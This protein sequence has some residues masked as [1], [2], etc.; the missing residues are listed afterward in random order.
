M[1]KNQY[2]ERINIA[3]DFIRKNINEKIS[4]Q[5]IS[6]FA[7]FSQYHFHRIFAA[8]TG[9]T[10][11]NFI[12]KIK[13]ENAAYR[14]KS[15]ETNVIEI[16]YMTGYETP[17]AFTRAFK[18]YYGVTPSEYKQGSNIKQSK[19]KSLEN[20][21]YF[22]DM[23]MKNFIGIKNIEDMNVIYVSKTGKYS[24][25]ANEAWSVLCKFAYSNS[26][27]KENKVITSDSK[28]IGIGYDDPEVTPEEKLRYD[29][30]ITV[31]HDIEISGEIKQKV[32]E[33]GKYAVF[34]HKG[35]YK[36]FQETFNA[37][38]S[39]WLPKSNYK[40]RETP[41]FEMYLN[42]D[43]KRTKPENLRTEIYIPIF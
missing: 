31:N 34:L 18:Q 30:C 41:C 28:F 38:F 19:Q 1:D 21:N 33:G 36:N 20:C 24:E 12:R 32:I 22:K 11:G 35:P 4:L 17:A 15:N 2:K 42:R 40:L 6:S 9:E 29:A 10:I 37:I 39:E 27:G 3:T 13:L 5:E 25:S 7:G 26:I 43:P 23:T 8:F 16:A 14:L